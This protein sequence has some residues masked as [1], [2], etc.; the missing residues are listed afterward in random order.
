M[1]KGRDFF[2]WM[3]VFGGEKL[4]R[5]DFLARIDGW[6]GQNEAQRKWRPRTAA[7]ETRKR[8]Q[9]TMTAMEMPR[10]TTKLAATR[11]TKLLK[12][13]ASIVVDVVDDMAV[14]IEEHALASFGS[15]EWP[16]WE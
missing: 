3:G 14:V 7:I 5:E 16:L 10:K 13:S 12:Q 1:G 2:V 4:G 15:V 11:A 9:P 6:S 8:G